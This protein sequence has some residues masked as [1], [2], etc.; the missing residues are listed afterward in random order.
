M[1]TGRDD[2][3][4]ALPGQGVIVKGGEEIE[5]LFERVEVGGRRK[6]I[7]NLLWFPWQL[8][9]QEPLQVG[10]QGVILG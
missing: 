6:G 5:T 3:R 9:A 4:K 7:E 2:E 8:Q 10:Q 1:E